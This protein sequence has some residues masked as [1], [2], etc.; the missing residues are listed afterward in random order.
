MSRRTPRLFAAAL[1]AGAL[2][3]AGC[4][5]KTATDTPPPAAPVAPSRSAWAT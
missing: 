2:L 1:A 4:A 5:E 3:L